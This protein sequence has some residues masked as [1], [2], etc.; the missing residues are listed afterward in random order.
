MG[1]EHAHTAA[2]QSERRLA[3]VCL[4]TLAYLVAEVVAGVLTGSLALLADAGHMFTDVA[5]L[6]LALFAI[7]IARRPA[8]PE[9]TYGY[10]RIEILAAV[11]NSVLLIGVSLYV[12]YE[13][14]ER[15]K[16]P[17]E[18]SSGPML[19]VA[20]VG[21]GVNV[22]GILLLRSGSKESLN[23]TGAYFEVLSDMLTSV[24]VIIAGAVMWA[25]GWYYADPLVSAGI[26]LFILP[27]T[28]KLLREAIG[29]LLEGTPADVSPAALCEAIGRLDGVDDVH[30]L[31]V[32]TITSGMNAMSVHVV[33]SDGAD[34]DAVLSRVRDC[35]SATFAIAHTTVQVESSGCA[36]SET[37]L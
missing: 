18:V 35:V 13:A 11:A 22:V 5:G 24:G 20:A 27:R 32:W 12:L 15:F 36:G 29:I 33:R 25:T 26:G 31:H 14:Y 23:V 37:H 17:P 4:L 2:G 21:L 3:V 10:Y 28:W 30:D 9:R 6:A 1:H 7:R 19:L 8:T 16:N 34:H